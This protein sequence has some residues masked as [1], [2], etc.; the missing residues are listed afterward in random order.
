MVPHPMKKTA[1]VAPATAFLTQGDHQKVMAGMRSEPLSSGYEARST[2]LQH[3][4]KPCLA[5]LSIRCVALPEIRHRRTDRPAQ[6]DPISA[7]YNS[8]NMKIMN[9]RRSKCLSEEYLNHM[10]HL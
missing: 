10:N 5:C 9:S 1:A 2:V 7:R 8:R 4:A 3:I 6:H